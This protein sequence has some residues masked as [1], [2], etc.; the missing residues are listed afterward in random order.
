MLL[1]C[2]I[3]FKICMN[4]QLPGFRI[5]KVGGG[6]FPSKESRI[7]LH[8]IVEYTF[9]QRNNKFQFPRTS[10]IKQAL[11]PIFTV[12]SATMDFSP[13]FSEGLKQM[14]SR[15][16]PNT[17]FEEV[18][19]TGIFYGWYIVAAGTISGFINLA[20]VQ[21]GMGAFIKDVQQE[22]GWSLAAISLG[23]SIKQ[24]EQGALGPLSGYLIDR[25]G[26]R[27][28]GS[29]GIIVM[30]IGLLLFSRMESLWAFY[31]AS[32][33]IALGQG[34]GAMNAF[35]TAI[36]HWFQ[37]KRGTASAFLGMGQAMGY[38]GVYPVTLLLVILGWRQAIFIAA[39]GF[40]VISLPLAQII[41]HRPEPYGYL[42]DGRQ[43]RI[44]N[45]ETSFTTEQIGDKDES[46]TVKDAMKHRA[47][48]LL[49]L[50]RA[51]YGLTTT[52]HHVHQ[53]PHMMN[54]GFST[55]GSG[56][57]VAYYGL[58]QMVG[59]LIFGPIADR[60]G[61]HRMY[62]LCF[63]MLGVGWF[64]FAFISPESNWSVGIFFFFY[65]TGHAAHTV[66][67]QTVVADF[68]GT[69]RYA[70]IRGIMSTLSLVIS[71]IGPV[72]AGLMFDHFN[73]YTLAFLILGPIITLGSLSVYLAG[74]PNLSGMKEQ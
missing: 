9:N 35:M 19:P 54:R 6:N 15:N 52:V 68:F 53:I 28:M 38:V 67:S 13:P 4:N 61:R 56:L 73:N 33:V 31:I 26:P 51:L 71:V 70:T 21:I 37:R 34:M 12:S 20:I 44:E 18:H 2:L 63:L 41:R 58:T 46:F 25:L 64:A 59:R 57:L 60:I 42:P 27:I 16:K 17:N 32:M 7:N 3:A 22:F 62:M 72:Y 1:G 36:V 24:F 50:A 65:G 49:V 55:Q 45:T 14:E 5:T 74:T 39:I 30:F 40:L 29:F 47:F 8:S 48:W 23:F 43:L 66:T 69:K 11:T 10:I